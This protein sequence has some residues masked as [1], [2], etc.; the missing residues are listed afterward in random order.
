M[1]LSVIPVSEYVRSGDARRGAWVPSP[2]LVTSVAHIIADVRVRGDAALIEY[3]RRY[4]DAHY[5]LSKLRVAIPMQNG[6]RPLVPPEIADALR[7]E[8]SRIERFHEQ[9]RPADVHYVDPDGTRY[10]VRYRPFESVAL[11]VHGG[12]G[13][14]PS[15][16]L[17]A[18]VPA[19]MAGVSRTIVMTPPH[20][21]GGVHPAVLFACS[22]CEVDELY[23]V[24]GAQA[25]AAAAIGTESIVPVE[26]IV[27]SGGAIVTEAKRQ[28]FGTAQMDHVGGP[29]QTVVLADE[30]ASSEYVV[31]ELLAQVERESFTSVVTISES[32]ALLD[33]VAQLV[34]TLEART[35]DGR[36]TLLFANGRREVQEAIERIEPDVLVVQVRDP[37]PVLDR[38]HNVRTVLVGDMTPSASARYAIASPLLEFMRPCT[39]VENSRE[40]MLGD[41][42]ELAALC[43][44]ESL[45]YHA[46]AA[47]LRNG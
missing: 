29:P 41:A 4:D 36:C 17:M 32:R 26:K 1:T 19:A 46:H 10:G 21:T 2:E 6:A 13:A 44:F 14:G 47:R 18:A 31:G 43:E 24:G 15:A 9:C 8:K 7:R 39:V 42:Q 34:D 45:P 35:L 25:I 12:P 38:I 20:E 28:L 16:V 11:Y 30:G 40:R 33:A 3:S 5:D 23:V 27:G 37:Q 22:L